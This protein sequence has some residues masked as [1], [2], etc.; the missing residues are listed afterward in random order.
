MGIPIIRPRA[1]RRHLQ[2]ENGG[3]PPHEPLVQ[4]LVAAQPHR[5]INAGRPAQQGKHKKCPLA[6]AP[7]S[8]AGAPFIPA[9]GDRP[10]QIHYG[11][12]DQDEFHS[13]NRPR[14][15]DFLPMIPY[16][17]RREKGK[18]EKNKKRAEARSLWP[19]P[20]FRMHNLKLVNFSVNASAGV[21]S[22]ATA[23]VRSA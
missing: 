10:R 11:Q 21:F 8:T 12:I 18:H 20:C 1:N 6:D 14:E 9:N 17:C 13:V 5:G 4:R 19:P 7:L 3:Q 16:F 2:E 22:N 23:F 15:I